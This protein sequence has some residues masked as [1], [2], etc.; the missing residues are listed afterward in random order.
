GADAR[1][2][3]RGRACDG[4]AEPVDEA[5]DGLVHDVIKKVFAPYLGSEGGQRAADRNS[6]AHR[7]T[8]VCNTERNS[9]IQTTWHRTRAATTIGPPS[10]RAHCSTLYVTPPPPTS[11]PTC[12]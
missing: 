1:A 9:V 3:R 5:A 7:E 4:A 8:P 10:R 11:P 2:L 12:C 6:I